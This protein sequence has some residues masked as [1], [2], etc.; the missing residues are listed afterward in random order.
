MYSFTTGSGVGD[1]AGANKAGEFPPFIDG[2]HEDTIPAQLRASAKPN[3]APTTSLL[4][5]FDLEITRSFFARV[6]FFD[7]GTAPFSC[8]AINGPTGCA[9]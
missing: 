6:F 1:G 5:D 9:V 7:I 4:L 8:A 3:K 2:F